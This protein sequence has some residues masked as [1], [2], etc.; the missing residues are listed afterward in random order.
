VNRGKFILKQAVAFA[1]S[2]SFIQAVPA[3]ANAHYEPV[4]ITRIS[5]DASGN[6]YLMVSPPTPVVHPSVPPAVCGANSPTGWQAVF[7]SSTP[8]GQA[9]LSLALSAKL[10]RTP[11]RIVGNGVCVIHG[12][13]EGVSYLDILPAN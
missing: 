5:I 9:M 12:N 1:A 6:A 7:N 8:A 2:L 10:S 4:I 11:V 3:S 13:I